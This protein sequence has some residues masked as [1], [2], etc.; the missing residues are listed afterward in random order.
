MTALTQSKGY[1]DL[2]KDLIDIVIDLKSLY[3]DDNTKCPPNITGCMQ[4]GKSG[5]IISKSPKVRESQGI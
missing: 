3:A 5:K 2:R 1:F 4:T